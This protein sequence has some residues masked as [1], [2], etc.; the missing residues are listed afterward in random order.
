M[1][2]RSI[3]SGVAWLLSVVI[4]LTGC[5]KR[6][7]SSQAIFNSDQDVEYV[8]SV[9]VDLSGS[10]EDLM[11]EKG[12]A[13]EFLL[14]VVDRYFRD[15]IGSQDKLMISQISANERSLLWEGTPLQLRREFPTPEAFRNLLRSKADPVGSRV[16]DAVLLHQMH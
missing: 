11:A 5:E 13:Y 15:R 8:L 1:R 7:E 9:I 3:L 10:F 2:R 6:R 12:K 4:F 16:N 14:H